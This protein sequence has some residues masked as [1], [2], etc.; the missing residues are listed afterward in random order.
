LRRKKELN[1]WSKMTCSWSLERDRSERIGLRGCRVTGWVKTEKP[2]GPGLTG[3]WTQVRPPP[4]ADS[5][6]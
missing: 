2:V 1:P 3:Y 5:A 6:G 4:A